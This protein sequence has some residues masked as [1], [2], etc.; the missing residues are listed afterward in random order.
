MSANDGE[1][2]QQGLEVAGDDEPT[3]AGPAAHACYRSRSPSWDD[4]EL[5][6]PPAP[7]GP[8]AALNPTAGASSFV[9]ALAA[10]DERLSR[11]RPS[12]MPEIQVVDVLGDQLAQLE[13][14]AA[15][16]I[17]S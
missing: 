8:W 7:R 16:A 13:V 9:D 17:G 12:D 11:K 3:Q 6:N 4:S 14:N 2:V 10:E 5:F 1:G 15:A